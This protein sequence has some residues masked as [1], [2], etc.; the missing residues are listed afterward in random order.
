[1]SDLAVYSPVL[2]GNIF[3]TNNKVDW[4]LSISRGMD[5]LKYAGTYLHPV[6]ADYFDMIRSNSASILQ[7]P[8]K[9]WNEVLTLDLNAMSPTG[10]TFAEIGLFSQVSS[11]AEQC[12][13]HLG[14]MDA[15]KRLYEFCTETTNNTFTCFNPLVKFNTT[16]DYL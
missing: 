7:Q 9:T 14:R 6:C 5:Q 15:Y 13:K 3:N 2:V 16:Q 10:K 12:L 8:A 11:V 1:M 4:L